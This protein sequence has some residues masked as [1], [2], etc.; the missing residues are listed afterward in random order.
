MTW[1]LLVELNGISA[2]FLFLSRICLTDPQ[3]SS[4]HFSRADS[5]AS[6]AT[7]LFRIGR[8]SWPALNTALLHRDATRARA[9][10]VTEVLS[11]DAPAEEMSVFWLGAQHVVQN[12]LWRPLENLQV[13]ST[14]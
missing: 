6:P 10:H 1:Y 4:M 7:S 11:K 5:E 3:E 13:C 9:T 2:T 8:E 12:D 14:S